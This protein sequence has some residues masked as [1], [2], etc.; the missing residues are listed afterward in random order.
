[1]EYLIAI[2]LTGS[3]SPVYVIGPNQ[4]GNRD[5]AIHVTFKDCSRAVDEATRLHS[6]HVTKAHCEPVHSSR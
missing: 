5:H 6:D 4:I 2:W 3:T 1:M